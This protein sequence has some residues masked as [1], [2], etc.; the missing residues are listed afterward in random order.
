MAVHEAFPHLLS[1]PLGMRLHM[2]KG[3]AWR[4]KMAIFEELISIVL[5]RLVAL[6]TSV[7]LSSSMLTER[8]EVAGLLLPRHAP[9]HLSCSIRSFQML[10]EKAHPP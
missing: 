7:N 5:P 6:E 4:C 9:P 1:L 3:V 2:V 8:R 10:D